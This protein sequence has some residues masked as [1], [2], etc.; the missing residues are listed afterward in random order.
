[1]ISRVGSVVSWAVFLQV[2]CV[3][4]RKFRVNTFHGANLEGARVDIRVTVNHRTR[5]SRAKSLGFSG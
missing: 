5:F 1:M 4:S 2:G 3:M